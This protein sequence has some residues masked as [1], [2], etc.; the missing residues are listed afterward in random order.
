[1]FVPPCRLQ[2]VV[3]ARRHVCSGLGDLHVRQSGRPR[4]YPPPTPT[5]HGALHK[6]QTR[7]RLQILFI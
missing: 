1:M 7:V 3:G 5:Q 2:D 6:V 4:P